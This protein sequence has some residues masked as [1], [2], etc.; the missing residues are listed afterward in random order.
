MVKKYEGD[1]KQLDEEELRIY[2]LAVEILGKLLAPGETYGDGNAI[3]TETFEGVT[4]MLSDLIANEKKREREIRKRE[5][6]IRK[7]EREQGREQERVETAKR[8][9]GMGLTVEQV[10]EG[11]C[12]PID[13]VEK[14]LNG[15][16]Q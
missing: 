1:I 6:E 12:L 14:I 5:M 16:K 2:G 10:A 4:G 11:S 13:E 8:F 15:L 7:Q 3:N 9:L